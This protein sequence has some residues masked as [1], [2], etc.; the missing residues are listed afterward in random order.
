[1]PGLINA[2]NLCKAVSDGRFFLAGTPIQQRFGI[3]WTDGQAMYVA[4]NTVLPPNAPACAE[5][6]SWGDSNDLVIPPASR[7]EGGVHGLMADGSVRFISD[8]IDT[9]NLGVPQPE[10]GASRYGIWGALGSKDG[11][12]TVGAF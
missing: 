2:P 10:T 3:R 9:G 11:D 5:D 4:F 6:G 12:D 7:H 1:V 8:N